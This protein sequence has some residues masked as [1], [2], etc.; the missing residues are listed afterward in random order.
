MEISNKLESLAK[1]K[2]LKLNQFPEKLFYKNEEAS[3]L[4]F[5]H[6]YPAKYYAIRDKSKAR[7]TFKLKVARAN[8][9]EEIKEYDLFTINVSSYN[10]I[11][12]QI[13]GGDI[14]IFE[15]NEIYLY[16]SKDQNATGREED[17]SYEFN[18]KTDIFD[19]RLN[20]I[21]HFDYLY[22]YIVEHGLLN[23]IVEFALFNIPVGLYQEPI[24]I[25]ELRTNY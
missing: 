17:V 13:L 5:I 19:S 1:I 25:Y 14:A 11:E 15:N 8:I 16:L 6:E 3:I 21:P 4:E 2:E 10:Y 23:I 7:G 9:L 20:D 24:I 12:N 22:K 18:L